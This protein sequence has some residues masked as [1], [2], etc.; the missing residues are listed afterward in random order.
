M[1]LE[2]QK[3]RIYLD[4]V[5]TPVDPSWVVVRSYDEFEKV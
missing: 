1:E 3:Y 5:R 2:K 4:D